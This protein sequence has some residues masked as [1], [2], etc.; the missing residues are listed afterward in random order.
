MQIKLTSFVVKSMR[1]FMPDDLFGR[2]SNIFLRHS[3][4][5]KC[6]DLSIRNRLLHSSYTV[7]DL[8]QKTFLA[9]FQPATLLTN[10]KE[11]TTIQ[12]TFFYYPK[13]LLSFRWYMIRRFLL[14]FYLRFVQIVISMCGAAVLKIV[15]FG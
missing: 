13:L 2:N 5:I 6:G 7:D 15:H 10:E 1:N 12:L 9:E 3:F 14:I 4:D 11:M 8:Q